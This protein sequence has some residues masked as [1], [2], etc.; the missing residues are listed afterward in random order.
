MAALIVMASKQ[1]PR[2]NRSAGTSEGDTRE[3]LIRAARACF[4]RYGYDRTT[5]ADIAKAAN[6]TTG[7][8]YH[9]FDS[10]AALFTATTKQ[11][12]ELLLGGLRLAAAGADTTVAKLHSVLEAAVRLGEQ[13][14]DL[15]RFVAIAPVELERRAEFRALHESLFGEVI[16]FFSDIVDE[17]KARGELR[18]NADSRAVAEML[19]ASSFGI[20]LQAGLYGDQISLRKVVDAF[21]L[22][23]G[24]ELF[25]AD[26][27][28]AG[29]TRTPRSP[30]GRPR[31]SASRPR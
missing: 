9:Y 7:A 6:I 24:G 23:L 2:R 10:K 31:K 12:E 26:G 1:T 28:A 13:G 21:E 15:A 22:L 19:F 16:E 14:E 20:A 11:V 3:R 5:N 17:G 27:R 8:I 4:A 25:T 29:G 30:R 18:A